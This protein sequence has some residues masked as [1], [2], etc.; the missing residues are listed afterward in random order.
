[1]PARAVRVPPKKLTV[2]VKK[3]VP[4]THLCAEGVVTASA[5]EFEIQELTTRRETTADLISA[6]QRAQGRFFFGNKKKAIQEC[7]AK[8]LFVSHAS[9]WDKKIITDW[10]NPGLFLFISVTSTGVTQ[11]TAAKVFQ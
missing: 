2:R 11:D 9:H 8:G 1:M 5:A 7:F 10:F 4:C 6:S 3:L